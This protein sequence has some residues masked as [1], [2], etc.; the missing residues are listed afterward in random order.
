MTDAKEPILLKVIA[1]PSHTALSGDVAVFIL[2]STET[3]SSTVST[4]S[5]A[6]IVTDDTRKDEKKKIDPKEGR[7]AAAHEPLVLRA[8]YVDGLTSELIG[9][10]PLDNLPHRGENISVIIPCGVFSRGGVYTLRLQYK[11]FSTVAAR[12]T[13]IAGL[14]EIEMS[15]ALD[16][17]WPT[18]SLL[19]ESQH[20]GT[21]PSQPVVATIKYN[22]ISCV[23]ANG[24]P[25][26]AYILQLI[27]CGTTAAACDPQNNSRTQVLYYEEVNGFTSPKV[28]KLKCEF[29]GMVG[30][31]ALRLKASDVNPSAPTTS[32]YIKVEW[33]DEFN[34]N[35]H[36]RSIY[37]CEGSAGI[38]VLFQYPACRLQG[39]RVRVYGR[40]R[41]DVSSLAPPSALH[42]VAELKAAPGKHS[43]N[44]D[45]DIFTEKFIEYCF[46]YV[47]QAITG[48]MAEVKLA[49]IPTF[50][51]LENDA[52]GWGPWSAWSPCS[53]SCVGGIRNRYRFCDTPPPKYGAKFCQGKAVETESCGGTGRIDFQEAWNAEGWECRHGTT[54]AAAR[55]E[56]TAQIGVQ[57]RCGCIINFQEK[58]LNRILAANTQACPGRS[59]WLLQA[60]S[61]YVIRLHLDQTQLP[62]PGQYFRARDGDSLSADLL[63]DIAFDK[64]AP[65]TGTIYSSGQSLLLEFF[66]GELIASGDSCVGGF[67]GHASM[68]H[69]LYEKNKTSALLP[70]ETSTTPAVE[71]W[72]FW[73][74]AHLATASL[75]ILIFFISIFLAL[76]F[77]LKYRKYHIAE[78]L[79]T[80]SEHSGCSDTVHTM[81][82][83]AKS[84]SSTTLISEVASLVG[85]PRKCTP[86]LSKRKLAPCAV[87]DGYDSSETLAEY[88]DETSLS[89][90]TL[91]FK[92][93]E[94]GCSERSVIPNKLHTA[95]TPPTVSAMMAV[96]QPEVKYAQPVKL[97]TLGSNSPAA[98]LTAGDTRCQSTASM[99]DSPHIAKLHR[100]SSNPLQSKDSST[101][102]PLS[103]VSTLRS[104]KETKDRRNRERLLQGPGSEFSLTNPET[105]MELDYYDYNVAN[106]GAAPGSYLGMD[107]AFLLWIPPLIS[108]DSEGPSADRPDC[109]QGTTSPAL[110]CLPESTEGASLT[111]AEYRRMRHLVGAEEARS[112]FEQ[113]RQ[114]STSSSSSKN[115]SSSSSAM[116][117][118]S[119][120]ESRVRL[121]ERL[122]PIHRI[123][124][125]SRTR[126]SE[127]SLCSQLAFEKTQC[128][129]PNRLHGGKSELCQ[130]QEA[131]RTNSRQG[132][133]VNINDVVL[134][135]SEDKLD[136]SK[137]AVKVYPEDTGNRAISRSHVN[138]KTKDIAG[139]EDKKHYLKDE[140][141]SKFPG[142]STNSKPP[143]YTDGNATERLDKGVRTIR[144]EPRSDVLLSNLHVTPGR[145]RDFTQF[146]QP[147]E[148]NK[149]LSDCTNIPMIEFSGPRLSSMATTQKLT[150]DNL[151]ISLS[152][153][154]IQSPDY[155]VESDMKTESRETFYDLIRENE[156]GIKFADDDDEYID[157]R[158]NL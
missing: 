93:N 22:G 101:S 42:Y 125:D 21:Y 155:G 112:G 15:S 94:E 36:A 81:V 63:T 32:A 51:L 151:N 60:K 144:D 5:V 38:S 140:N 92:D 121:N 48:A 33:S 35:V 108:E 68:F 41:A 31:Y 16:V 119:I 13:A 113:N 28:I 23:P 107:P 20:F 72:F 53:S 34:F 25:V 37:P 148:S 67:L 39:D 44:F 4:S 7:A 75:L 99:N 83:R 122:L 149:Q 123:L 130:E 91:K 78:D 47:S 141:T 12:H 76:Q 26:A 138:Q 58:T 111:P 6:A 153:Q 158:A 90:T 157:N 62:C 64:S 147:R 88:E 102:S 100:Y 65:A 145:Y 11:K 86:R 57:C 109:F 139:Q 52:A 29:F 14:P 56:V 69:K 1:P 152:K 84:M 73:G 133:L 61:D 3:E 8:L 18:P 143:S 124:E 30:N 40:L 80:L 156:D 87:E 89:S 49:C 154:E 104:G 17:K 55:P 103:G 129:I 59:F 132:S 120:A 128:V 98:S 96:G 77:A 66:S 24:V 110:F 97:R 134:T 116:S 46:S 82:G 43:L 127:E 137:Q 131:T 142:K 117:E 71:Q 95:E 54:L 150:T 79:D 74:P 70:S 118:D 146:T 2:D 105:D 135:R 9:D 106:A 19:L 50:P 85:L 136:K 114:D 45:C 115:D 126:V 27:Y 10:F